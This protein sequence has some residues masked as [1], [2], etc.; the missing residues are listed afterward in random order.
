[1]KLT[2]EAP[3]KVYRKNDGEKTKTMITFENT[4]NVENKVEESHCKVK[5]HS[6]D[7]GWRSVKC[8][9]SKVGGKAR[10]TNM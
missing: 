2:N 6:L 1:M 7:F 8:T 5:H 3:M 10:Y 9:D 4:V